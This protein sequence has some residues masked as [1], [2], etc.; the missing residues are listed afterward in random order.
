MLFSLKL[1]W[2]DARPICDD[3]AYMIVHNSP[4]TYVFKYSGMTGRPAFPRVGTSHG[5]DWGRMVC[6]PS[7]GFGHRIS[8]PME[9]L[10]KSVLGM[11]NLSLTF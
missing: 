9:K 2:K 11:Q 10:V 3:F 6:P 8:R 1:I 4:L 5:M 7:R